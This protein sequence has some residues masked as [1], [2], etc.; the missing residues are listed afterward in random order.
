MSQGYQRFGCHITKIRIMSGLIFLSPCVHQIMHSHLMSWYIYWHQ[1]E[2]G[3]V[4]THTMSITY[5]YVSA[6]STYVNDYNV[7]IKTSKGV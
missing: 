5:V 3:N 6:T 1:G 4:P 7:T 2:I